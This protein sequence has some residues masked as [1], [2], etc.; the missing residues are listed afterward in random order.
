MHGG[1]GGGKRPGSIWA[2]HLPRA[3][4]R[5]YLQCCGPTGFGL[6][7]ILQKRKN[8]RATSN[9]MMY[10]TTDSQDLKLKKGR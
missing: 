7:A 4:T 9:R 1:V 8:L 3:N 6:W 2:E 5:T 10:K